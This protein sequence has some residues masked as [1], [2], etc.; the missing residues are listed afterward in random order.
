M[1]GDQFEY[2]VV[3][4]HDG[5]MDSTF[6]EEMLKYAEHPDNTQVA[7]FQ[8]LTKAW[9]IARL[10]PRLFD[11]MHPL[12]MRLHMQVFN[13]SDSMLCW[14]H[15]ILCRTEP[16]QKMGGFIEDFATEDFATNL[17]LIECGYQSKAVNVVSY[18]A[19]SE[20]AQ[21]HAMR[22]TRW[23]RGNLEVAISKSW[24]LL[25]AT[26]LR[27]FMGVHCFSEWFFYVLG[28]L[29]T[30]WG[31]RV[32]WK[33]LQVIAFFAFRWHMPLLVWY[34]LTIVLFYILYGIAIRPCWVTRLTGMS[35]KD[36]WGH[37]ILKMAVN[38]Y[39]L[40]HFIPGQAKSLLGQKAR[41]IIGEKRW[42]RSSLWDIVKGMRWSMV[43]I[44]FIAVGLV[45]NPVGRIVHFI[46]Y[47]PLF[48]SPFIVHWAQ[49]VAVG[50]GALDLDP[51]CGGV[52]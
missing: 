30:V 47:I 50:Q 2:F 27:M 43:I 33:Q 1:Y 34:P 38:Y 4:D 14:G 23:A 20:T 21:F 16:F 22:M 41:F 11:A 52:E 39:A 40:F 15:N 37:S 44:A 51:V 35:W 31:Y 17:R 26:R 32:T 28:M 19:A 8:S 36:Y 9:N 5:I 49:N 29:L 48:L 13:Q 6:L 46:W 10:F 12:E 25:P 3:L 45:W 24:D 7:I 18:D 42:F